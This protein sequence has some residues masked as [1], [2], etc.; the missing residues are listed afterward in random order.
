MIKLT[1]LNHQGVVIN[2]DHITW[3]DASPDTTLVLI[4]GE[5]I[6][7]RES[8]DELIAEVVEFRR[9]IRASEPMARLGE[10]EGDP[11]RASRPPRAARHEGGA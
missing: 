11:P 9:R 4:G 3:V 7:V 1:R 6:I 8:V 2:P 10:V 5:K